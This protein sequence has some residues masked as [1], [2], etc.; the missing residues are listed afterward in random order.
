MDPNQ[1][2]FDE[3]PYDWLKPGTYVEVRPNYMRQGLVPFPARG[4]LVVQMLE[5]GTAEAAT[6]HRITR[7]DQGP[8]L[9]GRG[10]IGHHMVE[11]ARR[12]NK[13]NDIYAI[14]LPDAD[15]AVNAE[16]TITF[17]GEG[18]N[19]VVPLYIG[20]QR[21]R[22]TVTANM[23]VTAVAEACVAAIEDNEDLP[24]TADN[25]AG[26]VT[27]TA[28]HAGEAGNDILIRVAPR[29]DEFVP[30]GLEIAITAM[31]DGAGNPDI[32][33]VL[34]AI[35]GD[36]FTDI[37][38][39]WTD[40]A[41]LVTLAAELSERYQALGKLDAHG[42]V[43]LRGTFGQ[44][45]TKGEV[46]NS[47]HLTPIGAKGSPSA[48]WE[49][50]A[51]LMGVGLFHLTNDPARQLRSL[52]LPGVEAPAAED[53]FTET[54]QE[55]LLREGISTFNS[56]DDGTVTL[57]RVV[58]TYNQSNL[59]V[60]DRAWL[61]IMVPKTMTRIRYDW[62]AHVTLTY[63]RAKLADDDS[64]AANAAIMVDDPDAPDGSS[65]K[66]RAAIVTPRRMHATWAARCGLYARQ[67]WIENVDR[68]VR[69]SKFWRPE[70]DGNRLESSQQ[71][72][73][74]GNLMVLAAALEFQV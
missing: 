16:A 9:F 67:G 41:N 3:I 24:V 55:L 12:A 20:R 1:T 19:G 14:A 10:S 56:L 6:L 26:V 15:S 17:T 74:I 11:A 69:E 22:F 58:T 34:D 48:P 8:A 60:A 59:S 68:T 4:L 29:A 53:R 36:W 64:P 18:Y 38:V 45:G 32:Q 70:S 30:D 13:T 72:R 63:P 21:V 43:A 39:A 44:L 50:A 7:P 47:P 31:A 28:K 46:T 35:A 57:D 73:I 40:D 23:N 52:V 37:A 27:V 25:E 65:Q 49:W 61:D 5:S 54:E 62:A 2:F 42:Y 71:V 51:S 33:E 66:V